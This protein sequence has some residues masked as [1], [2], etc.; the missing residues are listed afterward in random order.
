MDWKWLQ[1][2]NESKSYYKLLDYT[3]FLLTLKKKIYLLAIADYVPAQMVQAL[4]AFSEFCYIVHQYSLDENYLIALK[5]ALQQFETHHSIFQACGI[6]PAE[7]S[8]PHIHALQHYEEVIQLFGA[9]NGLCPSITESKHIAAV[10]KPYRHSNHNQALHQILVI[11]QQLDNL[12]SFRNT[13]MA[14]GMIF[15]NT[16]NGV[17]WTDSLVTAITT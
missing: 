10:K 16:I 13:C 8:I 14:K 17:N 2:F 3:Y 5:N 11:N 7:T 1:S 4:A 12:K 15:Y 9:P 6:C